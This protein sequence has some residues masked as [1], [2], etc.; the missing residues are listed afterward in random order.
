MAREEEINFDFGP[1]NVTSPI[2][3]DIT[4]TLTLGPGESRPINL[5]VTLPEVQSN[6]H[7]CGSIAINS[8]NT[9]IAVPLNILADHTSLSTPHRGGRFAYPKQEGCV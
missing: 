4:P 2:N 9:S 1:A 7:F 5:Y 8:T 3:M 6:V